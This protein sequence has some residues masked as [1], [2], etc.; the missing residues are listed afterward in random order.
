M[1]I[2][3]AMR[4]LHKVCLSLLTTLF[5]DIIVIQNIFSIKISTTNN[6]ERLFTITLASIA[7]ESIQRVPY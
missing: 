2:I 4:G 6:T 1:Q 5:I 3:T 7:I